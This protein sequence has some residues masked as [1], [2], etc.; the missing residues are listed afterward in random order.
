[1][2][3]RDVRCMMRSRNPSPKEILASWECSSNFLEIWHGSDILDVEL[4]ALGRVSRFLPWPRLLCCSVSRD[5]H[6]WEWWWDSETS[7][8][9]NRVG[10]CYAGDGLDYRR[11]GWSVPFALVYHLADFCAVAGYLGLSFDA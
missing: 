10:H 9:D 11:W 7:G 3:I 1:M 8:D 6:G 4:P 5:A 2:I